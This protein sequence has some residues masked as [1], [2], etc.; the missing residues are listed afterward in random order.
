MLNAPVFHTHALFAL[1]CNDHSFINSISSE[2]SSETFPNESLNLIYTVLTH[3]QFVNVCDI[4]ALHVFQLVGLWSF[5][6]ATWTHHAG[7]V[8]HVVFNVTLV[9]VVYS[10]LLLI[11]NVHP[12]GAALSILSTVV[13]HVHLFHALSCT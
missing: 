7:S 13:L 1:T 12:V 9:V 6:Y 3:T 10:A 11:L 5:P 8:G 2:I 4:S